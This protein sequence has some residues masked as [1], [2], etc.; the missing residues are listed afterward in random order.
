MDVHNLSKQFPLNRHISSF[1]CQVITS[2]GAINKLHMHY[3]V[4]NKFLKVEF[5]GQKVYLFVIMTKVA[6]FLSLKVVPVFY[7]HQQCTGVLISPNSHQQ[8]VKLIFAELIH[9]KWYLSAHLIC[10][11]FITFSLVKSHFQPGKFAFQGTRSSKK[12]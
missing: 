3:Y 10:V 12:L 4:Q 6:R 9:E 11:S 2:N 7:S 8:S 5:L 1:K